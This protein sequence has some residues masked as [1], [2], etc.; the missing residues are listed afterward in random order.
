MASALLTIL[1]P[2]EFTVIDVRAIAT[3]RAAGRLRSGSDWP[4]YLEYLD[5]CRRL[6]ADSG[7]DLRSLDRG[8]WQWSASEGVLKLSVRKGDWRNSTRDRAPHAASEVPGQ[9]SSDGVASSHAGARTRADSERVP[10]PRS[11]SS[12][13]RSVRRVLPCG[14]AC[15]GLSEGFGGNTSLVRVCSARAALIPK[16]HR[17]ATSEA[18]LGTIGGARRPPSSRQPAVHQTRRRAPPRCW[19]A[20]APGCRE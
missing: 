8:L 13:C 15:P 20:G 12:F 18:T 7:T 11:S 17:P 2:D 5:L 1:S 6:A 14:Q 16:Q 3:L 4:P 10:S 9:G 19:C